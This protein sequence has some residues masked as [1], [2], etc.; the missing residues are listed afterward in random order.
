MKNRIIFPGLLWVI[1]FLVLAGCHGRLSTVV[2]NY[3]AEPQKD[4]N[5][6]LP[7]GELALRKITDPA[8]IPDYTKACSD[9]DGLKEAI[10]R[11]LNYMAK[12][13]SQKYY[14]YGAITHEQAVR[15]LRALEKLVDLKLSPGEMNKVLREKFDTYISVGC[16]DQGTVLF[17]GYYTPIFDGSPVR[18]DRYRYPLYKTP[19][20]LIKGPDGTILGQK[21]SDGQIQPYPGRAD[22]QKSN[23]LAGLEL[24]WLGDPFEVYIVHVQGSAKIRMPGG[25]IEGI[26]YA[27]HNGSDYKSIRKKM[28]A[29]GK[30]TEKNINMKAM[31]DYFKVH[32]D[33]VDMYV[34]ENPRFV[35]FKPEKGEPRGSL[36][37]SVTPFRTIATDKTIYPRAMFAFTAVDLD[38][39]VGF[40]L[41][42]DTGGAIRAAGRCDVYMGVGDHAGELAGKTYR[43]GQL[44]YIFIKPDSDQTKEHSGQK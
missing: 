27:A 36:N 14:P 43:E 15:S 16:D 44:Y 12:P 17:T 31:I 9:L 1:A 8:Q 41:D 3:S 26:G 28:I 11:S 29:D 25:Q 6:V 19:A 32:P 33:E 10:A 34:N 40:S 18:T 35:F 20:D 37:E 13:S 42:Q 39:P 5:R 38:R 7:P 4:Y 23:M 22:I 30:F 2:T 24:V 21:G